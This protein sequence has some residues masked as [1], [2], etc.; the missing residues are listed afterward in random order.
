ML[1][2]ASDQHRKQLA[3]KL[4]NETGG[5]FSSKNDIA[6][7]S[8]ALSRLTDVSPYGP[9]LG[10]LLTVPS[11]ERACTRGDSLVQRRA[12]PPER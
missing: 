8:Q 1:Y 5:M 7:S 2:L 12:N 9:F 4:R 10:T 11:N 3:V 6:V